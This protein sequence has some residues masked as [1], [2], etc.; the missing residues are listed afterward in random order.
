MRRRWILRVVSE[1]NVREVI[2]LEKINKKGN[3]VCG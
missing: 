3:S 2:E 1:E